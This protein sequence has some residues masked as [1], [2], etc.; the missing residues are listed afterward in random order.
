MPAGAHA[1]H[2]PLVLLALLLISP[3]WVSAQKVHVELYAESLCPY[4]AKFMFEKL[5]P[6]FKNGV[7]KLVWLDYVAYGNAHWDPEKA[8]PDCQHGPKE[9]RFNRMLSC[10]MAAY[11]MQA[12]WFPFVE[13]LEKYA[14][15]Q[16]DVVNGTQACAV[17]AGLLTSRLVDCYNGERWRTQHG[18]PLMEGCRGLH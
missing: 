2:A 8:A 16:D 18:V 3:L 4:C 14:E 9:C 5:S 10:A 15:K 13:C 11:P 7:E 1:K 12:D 17:K 6:M